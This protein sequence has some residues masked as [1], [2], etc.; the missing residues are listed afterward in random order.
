MSKN[1]IIVSCK[2]GLGTG[3]PDLEVEVNINRINA[4]LNNYP[5]A[6][7]HIHG[8]IGRV[9][10]ALMEAIKEVEK[11]EAKYRPFAEPVYSVKRDND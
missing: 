8:E 4:K 3:T 6:N 10:Q 2:F 11:A 5:D 7:G 1:E 9:K